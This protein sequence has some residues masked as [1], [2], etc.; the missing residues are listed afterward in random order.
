MRVGRKLAI[1]SSLNS[2][3]LLATAAIS[4]LVTPFLVRHLGDHHYGVWT[5]V[6]VFTEY[7]SVLELGL[8]AAVG[9]FMAGALGAGDQERS[10]ALFNTSL[11]VFSAAGVLALVLSVV[12]AGLTSLF[13]HNPQDATVFKQAILILGLNVALNFP[14]RVYRGVLQAHLRFATVAYTDLVYLLLRT[15]F[16]VGLVLMGYRVVGLALATL[17]SLLPSLFLYPYF[18]SRD[19]PFLKVSFHQWRPVLAKEL[20]SYGFY[21]YFGYLG[22]VLRSKTMPFIIASFM[23]ITMVTHYRLAGMASGYYG[24][25]VTA[26]IG[27]FQPL[28]SQQQGAGN[29]QAMRRTALFATKLALCISGFFA[30]GTIAFG[31]VFLARW[32]GRAYLDAY[33]CMVLLVISQFLAVSQR[34]ATFAIFAVAR[35]QFLGLLVVL[36]G[37]CNV[38]LALVLVPHW[39]LTGVGWAVLIPIAVSKLIVQPMYACR[40]TGLDYQEYIRTFGLTAVKMM[41]SLLAPA[42]MIF[43]LARPN[44]KS[45]LLLTAISVILYGVP[46]VITVLNR[47]E[48]QIL[49]RSILPGLAA[50]GVD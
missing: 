41:L 5:L 42:L 15:F 43:E 24:E 9:R 16:A 18:T 30:F 48:N 45:M 50:E 40:V 37:V 2:L 23:S 44:Y 39:G 1:G 22:G 26:L 31:K 32:V 49:W 47:R 29:L 4:F 27:V 13:V 35:H 3:Y 14:L 20:F 25:L 11:F 10:N 28:L 34:P 33:P 12:A 17:V 19:L 8:S 7:Y 46:V 21:S 36:E 38:V 6:V